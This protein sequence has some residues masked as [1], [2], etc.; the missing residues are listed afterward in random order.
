MLVVDKF[1]ALV[2]RGKT[3]FTP[4]AML[5]G[6]AREPV[7]DPDVE[8][9]VITIGNNIDPEV[10]ITGHHSEFKLR[11]VSTSLDMTGDY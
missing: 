6:S 5:P 2:F 7:S 8:H 11:D 4:L 10:L 9:R 3:S 1:L